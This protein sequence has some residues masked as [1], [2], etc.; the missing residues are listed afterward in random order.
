MSAA[1]PHPGTPYFEDLAEH[2]GA[3]YLR[4]S[5][6]KGADQEVA[7]LLDLLGLAPG[8]RVLDVGC[9]PGR[10]AVPLAQAGLT[11]IGVDVSRKFLDLAADKARA[12]GVGAGFFE[13]DARQMP[14][15]GEFDAVISICQGAFGL[16]GRD[17]SL[18]LRRM[19]E[20]VKP[21]G[22]VVVTAFSSYF[23]AAHRREGVAFDV[24]EGVVYERTEI[25]DEQGRTKEADM[26]TGVYTPRELKLLS[27]GVGLIPEA[28]WSVEPG[29]FARNDP[30]L[31]H[32]EF[33]L[34]AT[35]PPGERR[36]GDT[37]T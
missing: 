31:D 16:M 26:W 21:G 29:N 1:L 32:P 34:V 35:R 19:T 2:L 28:V 27:I 8:A 14:F 18:V 37:P 12:A 10:H 11:V 6:T 25:K 20:A 15:D 22:R 17:D 9:G 13:V 24:A 3:A 36:T 33:M 4:Y 7:F 30:D 5:F 23:E